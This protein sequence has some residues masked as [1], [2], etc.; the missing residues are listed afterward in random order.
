MKF[1]AEQN[2][3]IS[4]TLDGKAEIT[5]ITHRNAL[6]ELET[7]KDKELIVEVK[8]R[9]EKRT[10]SQNAYLWVLIQELANK[11]QL[12]KEQVYKT[13]IKDYGQYEALMIQNKAIEKFINAWQSNG[14]GWVA[15]I[16]RESK[17]NKGC[18]VVL[19]YYGSSTYD[20]QQ[21]NRLLDAV[22]EDCKEQGINTLTPAE[23]DLLKNENA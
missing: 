10:L 8:K 7:L 13:Y 20:R 5:F 4:L 14:L 21:M 9:T 1:T 3:K 19:A 17:S 15:E 16:M 2:P 11:L 18:S 23:L 6:V 22:I 12:S